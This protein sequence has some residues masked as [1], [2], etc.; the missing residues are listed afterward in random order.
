[1]TVISLLGGGRWLLK[2]NTALGQEAMGFRSG[3]AG[4]C[5]TAHPQ[6][7]SQSWSD[8]LNYGIL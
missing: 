7:A 1:M 3:L 6:P 5:H 8:I 4:G 2:W